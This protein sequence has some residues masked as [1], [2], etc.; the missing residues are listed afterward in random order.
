MID[1][2]CDARFAAVREAFAENFARRGERGGAVCVVVEGRTVV[3]LWGGQATDERPWRP[4]TLVNVFSVGKGLT[5]LL[6]ARLAGDGRLNVD[7]PVA[8]YW[9]EFGQGGKEVVTVRQLLSHQAG[10]PAVRRRMPSGAMLDWSAMTTALAQQEP[11]WEPGT[12]H[13]YH[14]NTFGFLVGEV[15]RRVTGRSVGELLRDEIAGPLGADVHIG[16]PIAEH[17]RVADF[18]WQEAPPEVDRADELTEGQ[19][20]EHN[21]YFNPGGLSGM[22]V[23]N[24]AAWREAQLPSTNGHGTARGVARVYAALVAGG[25]F[26]GVRVVDADA[27]SAATAEQASGEDLVMHRPAR[28]GTG[29]QLTQPERPLGPNPRSFGHFGAGGSLGFCDPDAGVAFGYVMNEMG[30]RWQNPRNKALVDAV[31]ASL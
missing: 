5:A 23:I 11:W 26:G 29:F 28:F 25:T 13:G 9:P 18:A 14:V 22:G 1:G 2:A 19:L 12:A 16:L 24:S 27:L 15:V 7:A 10:L 21:A 20:M 31:Y 3:D 8:R 4:D 6:V 30:P 17:R